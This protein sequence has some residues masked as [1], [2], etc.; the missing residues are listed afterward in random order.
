VVTVA[1][2]GR[3]TPS[4]KEA[5]AARKRRQAPPRDRKEA[6]ARRKEA[7]RASRAK[8]RAAMETGEDKYLP[9]RDQG[10]V[11]RYV[12][13]YVDS[14]RTIGQYFLVV[15]FFIAMLFFVNTAWAAAIG[16]V[17]WVVVLALLVLDSIRVTRGVKAGIRSRFGDDATK[18][19][20]M[21]AL[22]R[23]WQMRRLRLPKPLVKPGDPI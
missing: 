10:P 4:R 11:K 1:G 6:A 9:A 13:D 16:S 14:H 5:E 21:Y 15:F 17:A 23:A 7:I 2:K 3:A 8:T 19:I 22:M 18:R 12:R 20:T